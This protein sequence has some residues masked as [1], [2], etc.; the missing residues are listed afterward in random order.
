MN[1]DDTANLVF[2]ALA[3]A[4]AGQGDDAARHLIT[5]GSQSDDNRM[6]GVCCAIAAAG[7]HMLCQLYGERAPR[8][9][10]G[11]MWV[12]KQLQP[13]AMD[14]DPPKAFAARFLVAYCNKDNQTTLALFAAALASEGDQ[15]V[16]S[17]CAL[18]VMVAGIS[19]LAIDE[20]R[21]G[22]R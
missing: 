14:S 13:G 1:T 4:V 9:E 2:E 10:H 17:V 19:R 18:L 20:K 3:Y 8:P 11:D 22:Q 5:I 7:E 21:G 15:Y 12:L 6:Y 16:D